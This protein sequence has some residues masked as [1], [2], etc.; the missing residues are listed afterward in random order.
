MKYSLFKI[1]KRYNFFRLFK[2]FLLK[3]KFFSLAYSR[4]FAGN[5]PL[6]MVIYFQ[7]IASF[8]K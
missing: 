8:R 4:K 3:K 1:Q 5:K 7:L 6:Q 2:N